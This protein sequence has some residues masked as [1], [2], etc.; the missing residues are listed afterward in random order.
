MGLNLC[1]EHIFSNYS[2]DKTGY[3]ALATKFAIVSTKDLSWI[4][5]F[6]TLYTLFV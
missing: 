6:C 3:A 4:Q 2:L 5:K 1:Y